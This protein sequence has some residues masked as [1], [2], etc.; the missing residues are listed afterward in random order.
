M[1]TIHSRAEQARRDTLQLRLEQSTQRMKQ[2]NELLAQQ[3]ARQQQQVAQLNQLLLQMAQQRRQEAQQDRL[4]LLRRRIWALSVKVPLSLMLRALQ[5][6]P[7]T[8]LSSLQQQQ[9][10]RCAP[11]QPPVGPDRR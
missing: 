7:R 4:A 6:T 11:V 8:H 1:G 9:P 3:L 5:C 10:Q 2:D